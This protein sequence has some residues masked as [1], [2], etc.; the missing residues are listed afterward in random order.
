MKYL[1]VEIFFI[2]LNS[3]AIGYCITSMI[4][5]TKDVFLKCLAAIAIC[6]FCIVLS[7]LS[8][9][10]VMKKLELLNFKRGKECR[11]DYNG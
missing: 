9:S 10:T 5:S 11:G 7:L 1:A 8:I 3:I 2:I 6:V 4:G